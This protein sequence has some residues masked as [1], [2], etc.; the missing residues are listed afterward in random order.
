MENEFKLLSDNYLLDELE[1]LADLRDR[2]QESI[3]A[4]RAEMERRIEA[5][6]AK[7]LSGIAI[8]KGGAA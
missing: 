7:I 8:R 5:E 4:I 6:T 3:T 1:R 2:A